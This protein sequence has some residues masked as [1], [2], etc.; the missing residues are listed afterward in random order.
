MM[1][2]L[3]LWQARMKGHV[4]LIALVILVIVTSIILLP[5]PRDRATRELKGGRTLVAISE[6]EG[7]VA[8]GDRSTWT[9]T[10]LARAREDAGE[11]EGAIE[12]LELLLGE[13]PESVRVLT[14]LAD[15]YQGAGLPERHLESL[16]KLQALSGSTERQR[17]IVQL[18][19]ELGRDLEQAEALR[20]LVDQFE[21]KRDD[22]LRLARLE[23]S[24]GRPSKAAADLQ[25]LSKK[26][27]EDVDAKIMSWEMSL[28]V[29]AGQIEHAVE[30]GRLWLS[31]PGRLKDAVTLAQAFATRSLPQAT[32]ALLE[33]FASKGASPELIVTLADA[34]YETGNKS[35]AVRRLDQ[36]EAAYGSSE[37]LDVRRMHL[38]LALRVD[39]TYRAFDLANAIG[40]ETLPPD[41]LSNMASAALVAHRLDI[42]FKIRQDDSG[43][44]SLLN[45]LLRAQVHFA[46]GEIRAAHHLTEQ[47]A[48]QSIADPTQMVALAN[49]QLRMGRRDQA[50]TSLRRVTS[51]NADLLHHVQGPSTS[52]VSAS[53][54]LEQ[55][56]A[57]LPAPSKGSGV[58]QASVHPSL[59]RDIG[60]LYIRAGAPHEGRLFFEQIK[61]RHPSPEAEQAWAMTAIMSS[62]ASKVQ[63][64]LNGTETSQTPDM[65]QEL[66]Y[67]AINAQAY[68]LASDLA[69]V[70]VARRGTDADRLLL[71]EVRIAAGRPWVQVSTSG[72]GAHLRPE[73]MSRPERFR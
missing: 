37:R 71:A 58:S 9:L 41:L 23:A 22:Y 46:V 68:G 17:R 14:W 67:T 7:L 13:R 61:R 27:P 70:L 60:R 3:N 49:L 44:F 72:T 53:G 19:G 73:P 59:V 47:L 15:M 25:N 11:I 5:G 2:R 57:G 10:T 6:L 33:P 64:W 56:A 54:V 26:L 32:A 34:E 16:Q 66:I 51:M 43:S 50:L 31:S 42:L 28:W 30:R 18:L 62:N 29:A 21:G 63:A 4:P 55:P 65:L 1:K 52:G 20:V 38:Q 35:S 24:T 39:S 69:M 36:F 12:A 8:S 48:E 40:I 45:P